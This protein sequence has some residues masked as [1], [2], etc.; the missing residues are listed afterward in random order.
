[1]VMPTIETEAKT[2]SQCRGKNFIIQSSFSLF[3]TVL[4]KV[5]FHFMP[6]FFYFFFDGDY[7]P[8]K[9]IS[10]NEGLL[11]LVKLLFWIK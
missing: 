2:M 4:E 11:I 1:M 9:K 7:Y 3:L 5:G 10:E 6:K 8:R